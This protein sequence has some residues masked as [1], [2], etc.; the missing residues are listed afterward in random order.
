[1]ANTTIYPYGTNGQLPSSIG[2]INDLTTGGADKALSA[3]MGK[4]LAMMSGTYAQAWA[5]SKAITSPF[6]WL[7]IETVNGD[8][9]SKPIWH[10][11]NSVFID[12]AGA[13]INVPAASVPDAPTITG[14]TSGSTVPKNTQITIAPASGS[15]LYYSIDGGTTYNVSDASVTIK[16]ETAGSVSI[17]AYCANNAGNSS[18]ATLSVT[19]AGTAVPS[20]S[21]PS[22]EVARGGSVTISVPAGG[23]LHYKVNSGSWITASG[24]SVSIQITGAT[25]IQAYNVQDGDTSSTITNNYT[26]AAL[27]SPTMTMS[28]TTGTANQFPDGG[29][30]VAL[31]APA[32]TIYY[33]TDGSTPTS[34]STQYSQP[35]QVTSAMTIKAIAVDQYGSSSVTENAYTVLVV[36]QFRFKV[37]LS[38]DSAVT[39]G[40]PFPSDGS[41]KYT[42]VVD[43]GDG[44]TTTLNNQYASGA[45]CNHSYSYP[46][47]DNVDEDGNATITIK[48]NGNSLVVPHIDFVQ[49]L[50][51]TNGVSMVRKILENS[52]TCDSQV[53]LAGTNIEYISADAYSNNTLPQAAFKGIG[54]NLST[55]TECESGLFANLTT[56]ANGLSSCDY[57]FQ[58]AKIS[59]TEQ[60][61]NHLKGVIGNV[62]TFNRTFQ[63]FTGICAIPDD[64]FGNIA[65]GT[66][67]N[68]AYMTHGSTVTGDAGK[69]YNGDSSVPYSGMK[70]LLASGGAYTMA[71]AGPNLT[72]KTSVPNDWK[73]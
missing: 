8:A 26:M 35:I 19:V 42:C 13:I 29:G 71:L 50:I 24:T 28:D 61:M 45:L 52:L 34:S 2:I 9:I 64:F 16:L 63:N 4:R 39:V 62:T 53:I 36:P 7:W 32:G 37:R 55:P 65:D 47:T 38:G 43:W 33:T 14:A 41:I 12:A 17:V 30:T 60:H 27:A 57:M 58:G 15:A 66:V 18:N 25:A 67:T 73:Q 22:G 69:L 31:S 54:S 56:N 72:N 3:E 40:A 11:G 5:R 51:N 49:G 6:C 68:F 59:L 44:S 1:M 46:F 21:Q 70:D 48:P 10:K 23:E 20:F